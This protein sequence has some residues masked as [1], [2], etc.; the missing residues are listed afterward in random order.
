MKQLRNTAQRKLVK[1]LVIEDRHHPCADE[2]YEEARLLDP[3]ISRGTVYRNLNVLAQQGI[4]RRLSMPVG[5]DHFD[6]R[7]DYHYH[8]CC[9]NCYGVV[10]TGLPYNPQLN[11]SAPDLPGYKIEWHRLVL[12]G[13]CPKCQKKMDTEG[14]TNV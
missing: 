7:T 12:V 2:I 9:R 6:S 14:E 10:D 11:Q 1:D 13:L 4:I 8:F 3:H 5:P